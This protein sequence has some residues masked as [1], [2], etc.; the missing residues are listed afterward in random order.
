MRVL[1]SPRLAEV[2]LGPKLMEKLNDASIRYSVKDVAQGRDAN[3]LPLLGFR[4]ELPGAP[5]EPFPL[6]VLL[7][8]PDRLM[9]DVLAGKGLAEL[10]DQ[11]AGG[12]PGLTVLLLVVG[13]DQYLRQQA[14]R[15][16]AYPGK[17]KVEAVLARAHVTQQ[18]VRQFM[19]RD[20]EEA[21]EHVL[22]VARALAE[23]PYTPQDDFAR[24]TATGA[25]K[26]ETLAPEHKHLQ[27]IVEFL[28]CIPSVGPKAALAI[29]QRYPGLGMLM[30]ALEAAARPETLLENIMQDNGRRVGPAASKQ[31]HRHLILGS[32]EAEQ[33]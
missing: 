8:S 33:T 21:A 12:C 3:D 14:A 16:H 20:D 1:V 31:V 9:R 25:S 2:P 29:A 32:S 27:T 5:T 23:V 15:Q 19:A 24:A 26:R 13:L 7:C 4:R 11:V 28:R 6:V 22:G 10:L 30:D 17:P 18:A